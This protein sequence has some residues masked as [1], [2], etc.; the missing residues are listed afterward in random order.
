MTRLLVVCWVFGAARLAA[1]VAPVSVLNAIQPDW[2][3]PHIRFLAGNLLEGR[4]TATRGLRL[5]ADYVA[6]QFETLGLDPASPEGFVLRMPMRHSSVEGTPTLALEAKGAW[7]ELVYGTDFLVQPD[8]TRETV[9]FEG[10]LVFVGFGLTLPAHG[11]DDY[12]GIDARGKIVVLVPGGPDKVSSD[13]RGHATLFASKEANARAHGA[14]GVVTLMPVPAAQLRERLFRHLAGYSWRA[15]DGSPHTLFFEN[16]ATPRLTGTGTTALFELSGTPLADVLGRLFLGT[17]QSFDL[18]VRM[19]FTSRFRQVDTASWNTAG[20]IRGS[21]PALRD[22]YVVYTAHMDHVGMGAPVNGDSV[23]H[24]ALDN[25]G[26]TATLIAMARAFA[27]LPAPPRRSV[28]FVAVSGEEKGILGSDYFVRH[29]PVPVEQIVA[30]VN[31]DNYL[32]L[33]PVKDLAAYG[34]SYS[35]LDEVVRKSLGQLGV[36]LS[37]DGAPEQMIFTRSDHYPFMRRSIP[38]VMLFN[39]QES[40]AGGRDGSTMLR[41]WLGNVHHTPRDTYEQG[42]DWSAGV[43]YAKANFLI[44]YEVATATERPKWKGSYFFMERRTAP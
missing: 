32:M 22:E 42:I 20:V 3:A 40:G 19:R 10:G 6:A 41:Q 43:S 30:N 1:Q 38:A 36:A 26:G 21:D 31:M 17:P 15:P 35:T 28:M 27:S 39:G 29:P 44:G 23:H 11:Y 5:A 4:E 13:E 25:A 9:T 16:H 37:P 24:G 7:R 2:I 33:A 18:P 12:A 8:L 34:A 14:A